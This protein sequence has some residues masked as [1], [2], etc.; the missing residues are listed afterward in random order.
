MLNTEYTGFSI[1]GRALC[2]VVDP[3]AVQTTETVVRVKKRK[4][5]EVKGGIE[6]WFVNSGNEAPG[7]D[8]S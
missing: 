4:P 6:E 1:Y 2:L 5:R 7:I 8:D 3:P